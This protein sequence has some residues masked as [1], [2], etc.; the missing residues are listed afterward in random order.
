MNNLPYFGP[1][2][3]QQVANINIANALAP[4]WLQP[5][6]IETQAQARKQAVMSGAGSDPFAK[7]EFSRVANSV[8]SN[9]RDSETSRINSLRN[10]YFSVPTAD[11][12]YAAARQWQAQMYGQQIQQQ[13]LN[14]W[15]GNGGYF[16]TFRRHAGNLAYGAG[17]LWGRP[18]QL[19]AAS[20]GGLVGN[21]IGQGIPPGLLTGY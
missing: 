10:S 9:T 2:A 20:L 1:T 13:Q 21:G 16:D 8:Y 14:D 19:P 17:M 4:Q 3:W 11:S 7:A 15:L 12:E 5:G 6:A 18:K